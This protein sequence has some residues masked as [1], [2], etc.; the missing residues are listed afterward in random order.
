MSKKEEAEVNQIMKKEE[1]QRKGF[2]KKSAKKEVEGTQEKSDKKE[3]KFF[4][5]LKEK[6]LGKKK[7]ILIVIGVLVV[8]FLIGRVAFGGNGAMVVDV[9]R[10]T[11]GDVE[12]TLSTSGMVESDNEKVYYSKFAANVGTVNVKAGDVVK[13]GDVLLTYDADS[14][15]LVKQKA[16]LSAKVSDGNYQDEKQKNGKRQADLTEANTNLAVLNQQIADHEAFIKEQERV[17]EDKKRARRA[18]LAARSQELDEDAFNE[19]DEDDLEDINEARA[20]LDYEYATWEDENQYVEIQRS[21]EDAKKNLEDFKEYKAEMEAQQNSTEDAVWSKSA[22]EAKEA[23]NMIELMNSDN[24]L[25]H[26]AAVEDGLKSEFNGVVSSVTALN[27]SPLLEGAEMIRVQSMEDV[28]ISVSMSKYDLEK[29]KVGQKVD[30]SI[31][32]NDYEGEVERI[33]HIAEKNANN[34]PVVYGEINILNPDEN[35]VFGIEAKVDIHGETAK[36][37]ILIPVEAVNTDKEGDFVYIVENN[38][39]VRKDVV[40][41]ISSDEVIEVCEGISENDMVITSITAMIVEGATVTPIEA[42]EQVEE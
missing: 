17:L 11:K 5:N 28:N 30:I 34:T 14:L 27:G 29:V 39:V 12:A 24:I 10:A 6:K 38:V 1:K 18:S 9:V 19:T 16:E 26:I 23:A 35:I 40:L 13:K 25:T 36:D 41:G 37:A 31:A 33:N 4:K 32:G 42:I 21:I 8:F 2:F 20:Q 22:K 15:N 7:I 3:K